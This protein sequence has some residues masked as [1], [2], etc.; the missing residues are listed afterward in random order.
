[1]L[2]TPGS[3]KHTSSV[4]Y[5]LLSDQNTH[6]TPLYF[7]SKPNLTTELTI[8]THNLSTKK[9]FPLPVYGTVFV[10]RIRG[11]K[12]RNIMQALE[13]SKLGVLFRTVT[14]TPRQLLSDAQHGT[15]TQQSRWAQSQNNTT[16]L[17]QLKP[18]KARRAVGFSGL[19]FWEA[20]TTAKYNL[21]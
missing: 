18:A 4:R 8:S 13:V 19:V 10:E 16:V 12:K 15:D 17:T 11:R 1:M 3:S 6:Q 9:L 21:L 5:Q 14:L 7:F 2:Q 20:T